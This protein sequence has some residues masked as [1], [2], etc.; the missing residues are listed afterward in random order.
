MQITSQKIDIRFPYGPD[1]F[2]GVVEIS[3]GNPR[4]VSVDPNAPVDLVAHVAALDRM[5][6]QGV[7]WDCLIV[8]A[9]DS[10]RIGP[11]VDCIVDQLNEKQSLQAE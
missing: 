2:A 1:T 6:R 10:P 11:V 7:D 5:M 3:Y 4:R 8:A 9:Q